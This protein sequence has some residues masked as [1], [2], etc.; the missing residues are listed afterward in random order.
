MSTCMIRPVIR[1]RLEMQGFVGFEDTE[2]IAI[3]RWAALA[4]A[5][6]GLLAA[7]GVA[8]GSAELLWTAALLGLCCAF[9][10]IHPADALY[11]WF[12]RPLTGGSMLPRSGR[13]RRF[14]C[15]V[16]AAWLSGAGLAFTMGAT[17]LGSILA[18]V[19]TLLALLTVSTNFCFGAY[20][21]SLIMRR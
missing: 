8:L 6:T 12:V 21:Y 7:C 3:G 20:L 17:I 18:G 4:P 13:P 5:L 19:L 16:G 2:L 1:R 10:G 11:N 9:L 14:S 15:A